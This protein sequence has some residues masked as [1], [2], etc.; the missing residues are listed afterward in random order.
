MDF[1]VKNIQNGMQK[2]RPPC[3]HEQVD[4]IHHCDW[5]CLFDW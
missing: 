4:W 1:V 3:E 2:K 5:G